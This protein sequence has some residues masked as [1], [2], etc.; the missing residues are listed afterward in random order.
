MSGAQRQ[1]RYRERE[2]DGLGGAPMLDEQEFGKPQLRVACEAAEQQPVDDG[3][4][5]FAEAADVS[6]ERGDNY[7]CGGFVIWRRTLPAF[8]L[9]GQRFTI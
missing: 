6:A 8:S 7:F 2:R 1:K 5:A 9:P 3:L 4:V